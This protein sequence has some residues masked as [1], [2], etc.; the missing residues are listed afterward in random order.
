MI[1]KNNYQKGNI[2]CFPTNIFISYFK[3]DLVNLHL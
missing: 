3:I 2:S 1:L